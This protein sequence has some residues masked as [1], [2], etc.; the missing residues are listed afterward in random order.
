MQGERGK[1]FRLAANLEAGLVR[2]ARDQDF[3]HHLAELVDLDRKNA[4]ITPPVLVLR[5]RLGEG[6]VD[7]LHA[8]PEDVLKADQQRS[9]EV[10]FAG[11]V[12]DIRQANG[13]AAVVG[14]RPSHHPALFV[15]VKI[16]KAPAVDVVRPLGFLDGPVVRCWIGRAPAHG[17]LQGTRTIRAA[18]A[19]SNENRMQAR[20]PVF[21]VHRN[22][23]RPMIGAVAPVWDNR[24]G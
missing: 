23:H 11:F 3:L 1:Q 15:D 22:H 8:V 4:A 19:I 2:F 12:D 7:R 16:A 24:Y 18:E 5:D 13:C 14:A 20:S 21:R 17:I 10:A 6:G 9:A